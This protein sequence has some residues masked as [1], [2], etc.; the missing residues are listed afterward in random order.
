MLNG[1]KPN[2]P[3]GCKAVAILTPFSSSCC[4][5]S[6]MSLSAPS[7]NTEKAYE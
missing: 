7:R 1:G 3:F 4:I 5:S 2:L 6:V